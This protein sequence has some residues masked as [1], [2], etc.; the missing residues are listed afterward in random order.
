MSEDNKPRNDPRTFGDI[1][2]IPVGKTWKNRAECRKDGVHTPL[3][4][5]IFGDSVLGAYS[6]VLSGGYKDDKD[7]GNTFI[8]TGSGGK[9]TESEPASRQDQTGPQRSDQSFTN[10]HNGALQKN[11]ETRRPVRVVRGPNPN[12]SFGT[13]HGYRYDGLY[14]V[15]R[16]WKEPGED[17]YLVCKFELSRMEGQSPL[18]GTPRSSVYKRLLSKVKGRR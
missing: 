1:L 14:L 17:G 9:G 3:E 8:Y 16:A 4:A 13:A 15:D 12:S 7:L 18:T 2:D 5:G 10:S 6:I 11:V